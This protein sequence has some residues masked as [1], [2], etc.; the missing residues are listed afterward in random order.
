MN[1]KFI[2]TALVSGFPVLI[3]LQLY[4]SFESDEVAKTGVVPMPDTT[5]ETLLG[6]H[7]VQIWAYNDS[8]QLFLLSNSWGKSWGLPTSPGYFTMPYAYILDPNLGSDYCQIR[9]FH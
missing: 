1:N 8:T 3:G 9:Y 4:T 2:K 7:A 6:G 5:K